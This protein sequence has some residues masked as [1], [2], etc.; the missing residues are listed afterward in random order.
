MRSKPELLPDFLEDVL[1]R[2]EMA[3]PIQIVAAAVVEVAGMAVAP[4]ERTG[5][6]AVVAD[7]RILG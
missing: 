1:E 3:A 5:H 2:A 7:L 6:Q 4:E